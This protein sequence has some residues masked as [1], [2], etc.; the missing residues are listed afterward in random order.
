MQK[1][2]KFIYAVLIVVIIGGGA[3]WL[4]VKQNKNVIQDVVMVKNINSKK[5]LPTEFRKPTPLPDKPHIVGAEIERIAIPNCVGCY[6]DIIKSIKGVSDDVIIKINESLTSSLFNNDSEKIVDVRIKN[7]R[8]IPKDS[9]LDHYESKVLYVKNTDKLIIYEYS[10]TTNRIFSGEGFLVISADGTKV[11][12]GS[13]FYADGYEDSNEKILDHFYPNFEELLQKYKTGEE[14]D[15][16][17]NVTKSDFNGI[18]YPQ[19]KEVVFSNLFGWQ[20]AGPCGGEEIKIAIPIADILKEVPQ[21]VPKNSV[22]W[23]FAE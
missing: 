8:K 5:D 15:C 9:Y 2:I 16:Y 10:G 14:H 1:Q 17:E 3:T 12:Y 7:L 13:L 19:T 11:D 18:P 22:L 4:V 20:N 6:A 23:R 21:Y